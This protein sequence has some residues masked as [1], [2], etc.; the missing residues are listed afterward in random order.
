MRVL[1]CPCTPCQRRPL[2]FRLDLLVVFLF[3]SFLF[4]LLTNEEYCAP[5]T[6]SFDGDESALIG[7]FPMSELALTR[8]SWPD[9]ASHR[10]NRRR[11][12]R[13]FPSPASSRFLLR[14][15]QHSTPPHTQNRT[16][17]HSPV[18]S[19]SF[20]TFRL[21]SPSPTTHQRSIPL[22]Q[23]PHSPP[24]PPSTFPSYSPLYYDE[25]TTPSSPPENRNMFASFRRSASTNRS[26]TSFSQ[27]L[28]R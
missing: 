25:L 11:L 17:S 23:P 9:V 5:F 28:H 15:S 3:S 22:S 8:R 2:H 13:S 1:Y 24:T 7:S 18:P 26:L 19:S 14:R 10:A 6:N 16:P 12:T 4:S 27:V 21:F 20:V